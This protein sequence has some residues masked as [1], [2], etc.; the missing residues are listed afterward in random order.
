MFQREKP[1]LVW[2]I[3]L[4]FRIGV[5]SEMSRAVLKDRRENLKGVALVRLE[6]PSS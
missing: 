3:P 1:E 5:A 2:N 4:L 6:V